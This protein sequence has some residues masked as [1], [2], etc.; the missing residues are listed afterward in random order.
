MPSKTT[1]KSKALKLKKK[2][3]KDFSIKR[4]YRTTYKDIKNYFKELT[5]LY[6]MANFHHLVK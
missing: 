3:K 2:L 5:M 6:L 1:R 4:K